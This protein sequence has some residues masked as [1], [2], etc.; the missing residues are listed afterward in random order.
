[1]ALAHQAGVPAVRT[2]LPPGA[3]A[4]WDLM[5]A[6]I[7]AEAPFWEPGT[8]HGYHAFT[9]GW[10][11]GELVQRVSGKPF[12][13]F[14][15]DEVAGPLGLDFHIGLHARDE[16]RVAPTIPA[17]P[18]PPEAMAGMWLAA[19]T[20]PAS[21]PA[22]VLAN[23]GGYL[24]PGAADSRAMHSAVVPAAGGI[25]NARGL[26]HMYRPLALGGYYNGVRL[27]EP[28]ALGAM[29]RVVSSTS[30]DATLLVPTRWSAGFNKGV[31]NR[32]RAREKDSILLSES[33]FGHPGMGGSIGFADPA[34]RMSFG[35]T[36]NRQGTS[37]GIDERAQSLID[38]VY[39]ALGYCDAPGGW[40]R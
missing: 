11:I 36:M 14:F 15:R 26:A 33:A 22:M 1:M 12:A 19:F 16:P 7:A 3:F 40:V 13:L 5:T 38:A 37:L 32:G 25:T 8:R 10:L 24:E 6:A 27:V 39:R 4:D 18:P 17:Q 21:I 29:E 23:S 34:A 28:W 35:Y 2:P 30:V 9:F 20:D 31:D